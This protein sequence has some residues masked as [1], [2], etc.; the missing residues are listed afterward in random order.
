MLELPEN[1]KDLR[2]PVIKNYTLLM[3]LIIYLANEKIINAEKLDE[4]ACK[5]YKEEVY[6]IL[7]KDLK[8]DE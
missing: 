6:T 5:L 2:N 7:S 1:F 4:L 8:D 3:S